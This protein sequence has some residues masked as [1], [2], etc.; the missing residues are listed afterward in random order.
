MREETRRAI[1]N[2]VLP[3]GEDSHRALYSKTANAW[4]NMT[5]SAD[6]FFDHGA[7]AHVV[8]TDEGLYHHGLGAHIRLE[9]EGTQFHGYDHASERRFNGTVQGDTAIVYDPEAKRHHLYRLQGVTSG[10]PGAI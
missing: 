7:G 9:V 3:R 5:W 4:T 6:G 1:A 8:R 2:A 10:E